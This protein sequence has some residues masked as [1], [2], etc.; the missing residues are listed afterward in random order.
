MRHTQPK[1]CGRF[2]PDCDHVVIKRDLAEVHHPKA[3]LERIAGPGKRC[4]LFDLC[5]GRRTSLAYDS[6]GHSRS[7]SS[8]ER[9]HLLLSP[10]GSVFHHAWAEVMHPPRAVAPWSPR[11]GKNWR[12]RHDEMPG[13]DWPSGGSPTLEALVESR[14]S[15]PRM[16]IGIIF[17]TEAS[18]S[19]IT[20]RC[21][22]A[23]GRWC[24]WLRVP[25]GSFP[26]LAAKFIAENTHSTARFAILGPH[27]PTPEFGNSLTST[28]INTGSYG[29]PGTP[30]AV[31]I[32]KEPRA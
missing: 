6:L 17:R 9:R 19:T 2:G 10:N 16:A 27:A 21:W 5:G 29:F 30:W 23:R 13:L 20:G 3:R 25:G 12:R 11:A 14:R 8:A 28:I 7:I 24:R 26:R 1:R 32:R 22:C 15:M 4:G 18:R 31:T